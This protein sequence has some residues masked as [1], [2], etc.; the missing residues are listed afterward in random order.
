VPGSPRF[1]TTRWSVVLAA[2][3]ARTPE[4]REAL[5]VLCRAY[6]YP[7]YAYA[8]RKGHDAGDAE[9]AVQEFFS[10]LLASDGL[11]GADPDRGRFRAYLLGC[12]KHHL[13]DENRARSALKRGG[14]QRVLSLDVDRGENE[15]RLSQSVGHEITP[16][17]LY[18]RDWALSLLE[19]ALGSVRRS[20]EARG[21]SELFHALKDLLLPGTDLSSYAQRAE[22]LGMRVGAVKV[23]IHRL[24]ARYRDALVEA[25]VHTVPLHG[26]SLEDSVQVELQ[27]LLEAL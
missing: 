5:E 6:W 22:G 2:G 14:G 23:A 18:E 15:R 25:V 20:Y 11:S 26:S 19:Q 24:R 10:Q 1:A 7:L 3:G 9:D 16:E 13:I 8:R 4:A 21:R 27:R 17:R 12:F